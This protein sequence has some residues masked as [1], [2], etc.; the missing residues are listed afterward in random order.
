MKRISP[1]HF[2]LLLICCPFLLRAQLTNIWRFGNGAGLDFNTAIP[3]PMPNSGMNT[4]EGTCSVS[5]YSGNLLFYTNGNEA[6]DRNNVIMPNG[7]GLSGGTSATQTL[8]VPW[9]GDCSKYFI[10]QAS[11]HMQNGDFRYSVVDMCLNNGFGDVVAGSKNIFLHNPTSEKITA[12]ANS[13]GTDYWII[14]HELGTA[15]FRV[16]PVTAAGVGTATVTNIGAVHAANCMIGPMKASPNGQKLVVENTFCSQVQLFDFNPATGAITNAVTLNTVLPNGGNGYYGAEFSPN[17]QQLYLSCTWINDWLIQYDLATATQTVLASTSGN[18]VYGGLQLGPDGKVYMVQNNQNALD[19]IAN[20]NVAGTGCNYTAAS[21]PLAAGT[22]STMGIPNFIPALLNQTTVAAPLNVNLGNDTNVACNS[23]FSLILDAGQ[24]CSAQYLWQ[25]GDTTQTTTVTQAGTYYVDVSSPCGNGTDTI[26]VTMTNIPPVVQLSAPV[27]ICAGQSITLTAS[28]ASTYTWPAGQGFNATY[29]DSATASPVSSTTYSVIGT[30]AC[31]SDTAYILVQTTPNSSATAP[32]DTAICA[33]A[34]IALSAAGA[35]TYQ[36][37]GGSTATTQTISVSP[38]Q[39]T[40]Y[41]VSS[42]DPCPLAA[43]TVTVTVV[44]PVSA[45]LTGSAIACMGQAVTLTAS[46]G[47][48][49]TW[50]NG[51]NGNGNT[52]VVAP[53]TDSAFY[54]VV[55]DGNCPG[56]TALFA[57]EITSAYEAAFSVVQTPCTNEIVFL[58]QATGGSAFTWEFGDGQYSSSTQPSHAYDHSGSYQ[59]TFIVNPNMSCSDSVTM[60]VDY[61]DINPEAIWIPNAFTPNNDGRNEVF[62]IYGPVDC[63]YDRL[64]I[65]NRW[66]E[67]IWQTESPMTEFWDGRVDGKIVQQ[68]VYVYRLEG[69]L[70]PVKIGSVTVMR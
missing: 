57:I 52:A 61:E 7:S 67:L 26:V 48:N 37:G 58:N 27:Q 2:V 5:D 44:P 18:Y 34:S 66:G 15:N 32:A 30:N 51:V 53:V 13:N 43:D 22:T 23:S 16:Y 64:M 46:G 11:D 59:V 14:T 12:V 70:L 19:V 28:G 10:F 54:V 33:G 9:P 50:L 24:F 49:Y 4:L 56:D 40:V 60:T 35:S 69:E 25:N 31:G 29:P 47:Q 63:F 6:R 62:R 38:L 17:S 3:T 21:Q 65:F 20:P 1:I 8:I 42:A 45:G 68:G 41:Y 36:W 55:S 39:T